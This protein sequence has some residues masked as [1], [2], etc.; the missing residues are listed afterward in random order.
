MNDSKDYGL[1]RIQEFV[2][3][4][5]DNHNGDVSMLNG[6]SIYLLQTEDRD[7]NITGEAF[8]LNCT[9][10]RYFEYYFA[11]NPTYSYSNSCLRYIFIGNGTGTIDPS[12]STLI[13]YEYGNAATLMKASDYGEQNYMTDCGFTYDSDSGLLS[14]T[15]FICQGYFDYVLSGISSQLT[16]TEIGL[17]GDNNRNTL[18]TH[19][20]VCDEYGQQASITKN[21]NEKLTVKAYITLY[22]KPGYIE[23][24]MESQ[25]A[26]FMWNPWGVM[27]F[28]W[29]GSSSG[30]SANNRYNGTANSAVCAYISYPRWQNNSSGM[31]CYNKDTHNTYRVGLFVQRIRLLENYGT[32]DSTNKI[33]TR[34]VGYSSE[35]ELMDANNVYVDMFV[36][37]I[38]SCGTQSSTT[39]GTLAYGVQGSI[40]K[41][42]SLSTPEEISSIYGY[43]VGINSGDLS[44]NSGYIDNSKYSVYGH[45]P[46][47]NLNNVR[48]QSYN[49]LT[50]DWDIVHN[51]DNSNNT[52]NLTMRYLYTWT[53]ISMYIT[54]IEG[55][56]EKYGRQ[57]V[58]I[59]P[60]L[61]TSYPITSIT[62]TTNAKIKAENVWVS[63]TYWDPS[64]WV[65]IQDLSN[66]PASIGTKK[67][68][69]SIGTGSPSQA[70][71]T[72][73][74][75]CPLIVDRSGYTVPTL[76]DASSFDPIN[77]GSIDDGSA[78]RY[79]STSYFMRYDL[80]NIRFI[81]NETAGYIY[82]EN[83][84]YYPEVNGGTSIPITTS[85]PLANRS[86]PIGS[87]RFS[88]PSGR[89]VLQIFRSTGENSS[90]APYLSKVSV[91]DIPTATE[92]ENDPTLT[93]TETLVELGNTF[94]NYITTASGANINISSTEAGYVV[95]GNNQTTPYRT[96][97]V[98]ILGDPID[99]IPYAEI[100]KYP[101]TNDEIPTGSCWAIKYTNYV[102]CEDP[103][104]TDTDNLAYMIIDLSDGSLVER[105]TIDRTIINGVYWVMGVHNKIYLMGRKG[106][107]FYSDSYGTVLYDLDRPSGSRLVY[108]DWS[109]TATKG[110][111]PGGDYIV[112]SHYD[113]SPWKRY[114]WVKLMCPHLYGD[115]TCII[116]GAT[117]AINL[118]LYYI[119][120]NNPETIINFA[121]GTGMNN[122]ELFNESNNSVRRTSF[123]VYSFN[124][125][126]QRLLCVDTNRATSQVYKSF[127]MDANIIRDTKT[128]PSIM[129]I[130][131]AAVPQTISF[132]ATAISQIYRVSCVYKNKLLISEYSP[133]YTNPSSN[134]YYL[135]SVN[136]HRFVD[137]NRVI[138]HKITCETTTIQAYNNPKLLYGIQNFSMKIINN[139]SVYDPSQSI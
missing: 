136:T 106:S 53:G 63:D 121:S 105:F 93:P 38:N 26:M 32:Y 48:L 13:S 124:D 1:E 125:N 41:P 96:H 35:K 20:F 135:S 65:R 115:E 27:S 94:S 4:F 130:T 119:D 55:G 19:A 14:V 56:I 62:N 92:L 73:V 118:G 132:A 25:G 131:N 88:E 110:L 36:L 11:K 111:M 12:S 66:I 109:A 47:T 117:Q 81:P 107:S 71:G 72:G 24:K 68:I 95:F 82:M 79:S 46:I 128:G 122:A 58:R 61:Y 23:A 85:A 74:K 99:H 89:R 21:V 114:T 67:Y 30:S 33:V 90:L 3:K 51:V 123:G 37:S 52:F 6:H 103:G 45:L 108:L 134:N 34:S 18:A 60:N 76:N 78:D 77:L 97:I 104:L 75:G 116:G 57:W 98:N 84:I 113:D 15:S 102:V 22:H 49:G 29:S 44:A 64:S 2:R 69:M 126:K 43:C 17:N 139:G 80:P 9:T 133:N 42:I 129:N 87:L 112:S 40:I 120:L 7:G 138:Q 91:F 83:H 31:D 10:D 86:Y 70:W 28:A 137:I 50:K 8:A 101:G 54:Y 59:Y 39:T 5:K 127:Y 16:I 100:L